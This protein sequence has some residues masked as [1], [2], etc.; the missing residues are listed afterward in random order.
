MSS[1]LFM[2]YLV[3]QVARGAALCYVRLLCWSCYYYLS[4]CRCLSATLI[5]FEHG[6]QS[7]SLYSE[8]HHARFASS[9]HAYSLLILVLSLAPSL[10]IGVPVLAVS[11]SSSVQ[12]HNICMMHLHPPP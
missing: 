7:L 12:D 11:Q 9:S 4:Q 6:P 8:S 5:C 10:A 3:S 2:D 1:F